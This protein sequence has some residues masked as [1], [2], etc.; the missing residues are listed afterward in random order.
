MSKKYIYKPNSQMDDSYVV[1]EFVKMMPLLEEAHKCPVRL[2]KTAGVVLRY[3][4][5][6]LIQT[7]EGDNE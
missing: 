2:V 1:A 5:Y 7:K 4:V 6:E 3:A